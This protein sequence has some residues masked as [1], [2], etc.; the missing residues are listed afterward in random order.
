MSRQS[1]AV[2]AEP[3]GPEVRM[4]VHR[5]FAQHGNVARETTDDRFGYMAGIGETHG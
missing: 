3:F 4:G 5:V 1:P 2:F